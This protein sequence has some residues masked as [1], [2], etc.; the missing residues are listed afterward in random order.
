TLAELKDEESSLPKERKVLKTE[1]AA[2]RVRNDNIKRA[3]IE[4]L[5]CS[6]TTSISPREESLFNHQN[7]HQRSSDGRPPPTTTMNDVPERRTSSEFREETNAVSGP[8]FALP[9]LNIP[10]DD[11]TLDVVWRVS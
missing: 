10:F 7:H 1:M 11:P 2:L 5:P 4:F 3:K 9:D 6:D 8:K